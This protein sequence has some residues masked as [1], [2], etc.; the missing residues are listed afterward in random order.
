MFGGDAGELRTGREHR[1]QRRG[2]V[3]EDHRH[4]S[5]AHRSQLTFRHRQRVATVDEDRTAGDRGRARKQVQHGQA[6]DRLATAGLTHQGDDLA[7]LDRQRYVVDGTGHR[8]PRVEADAQFVDLE[9][10]GHW[11]CLGS[12]TSRAGVSRSR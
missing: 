9:E 6:G 4:V 3:L 11:R 8:A 12:N 10:R 5:A 7:T 2:R 1:V